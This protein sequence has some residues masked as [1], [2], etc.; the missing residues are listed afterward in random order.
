MEI[1]FPN[2]NDAI[3]IRVVQRLE[4]HSI[5][6]RKHD[7]GRTDADREGENRHGRE[8]GILAQETEGE[9]N[10]VHVQANARL[11]R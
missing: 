5:D 6:D 3:R 2:K 1:P 10:V 11:M 4:E 8:A 9:T 7:R